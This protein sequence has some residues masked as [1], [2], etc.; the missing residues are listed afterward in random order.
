LSRRTTPTCG[1][2]AI[3]SSGLSLVLVVVQF[4][5]W[6]TTPLPPGLTACVSVLYYLLSKRGVINSSRGKRSSRVGESGGEGQL[7]KQWE[8]E[9]VRSRD[10]EPRLSRIC[11]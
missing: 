7:P 1:S 9:R 10:V 4:G 8:S 11:D 6:T 2:D 3:S 5:N